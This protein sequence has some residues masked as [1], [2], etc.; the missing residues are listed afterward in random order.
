MYGAPEAGLDYNTVDMSLK[1]MYNDYLPPYKAAV[2]AGVLSVMSAY[3]ELNGIPISDFAWL[4]TD[5]LRGKWGFT[6][7]VVS[8]W[9]AISEV[10]N[11]G[12]ATGEEAAKYGLEAGVD[13][14]M[15][16]ESYIKY[17][18]GLIAEG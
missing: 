5:L 9:S 14:D 15:V 8:D 10:S 11:H 3:H 4:L 18:P 7:Y 6:G 12:Y 16:A 2:E 1:R 17:L 13:S